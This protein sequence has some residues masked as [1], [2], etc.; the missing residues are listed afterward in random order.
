MSQA[1]CVSFGIPPHYPAYLL[2]GHLDLREGCRYHVRGREE[3]K[4][5]P[6]RQ[7][8]V[9]R[10]ALAGLLTEKVRANKRGRDGK[11]V[12]AVERYGYTQNEVADFLQ[13]HYSTISKLVNGKTEG[14]SRFKT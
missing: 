10:P 13:M 8:Y 9:T 4:E 11:I 3:I 2:C 5:I 7:R 1:R 12:E 14:R 6:R